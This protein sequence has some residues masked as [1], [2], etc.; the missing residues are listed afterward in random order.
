MGDIESLLA[1]FG[2]GMLVQPAH[3][4]PNV[5]DLGPTPIPTLLTWTS[6]RTSKA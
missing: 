4:E 5:V 3:E 1:A 2:A 6:W